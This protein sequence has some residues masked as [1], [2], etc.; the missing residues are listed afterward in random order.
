[1]KFYSNVKNEMTVAK[2]C[3]EAEIMTLTGIMQTQTDKQHIVFSTC[4]KRYTQCESRRNERY[5][6]KGKREHDKVLGYV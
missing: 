5:K 1:M 3:M 6:G 2:E 4:G